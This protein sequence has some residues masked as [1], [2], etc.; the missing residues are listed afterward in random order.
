MLHPCEGST[1]ASGSLSRIAAQTSGSEEAQHTCSCVESSMKGAVGSSVCEPACSTGFLG[2]HRERAKATGRSTLP[3]LLRAARTP[4]LQ[5]VQMISPE[6]SWTRSWSS[7]D[8][9]GRGYR[10]PCHLARVENTPMCWRSPPS[11]PGPPWPAWICA[12]SP[13]R[14]HRPPWPPGHPHMRRSGRGS[15]PYRQAACPPLR[16]GWVRGSD[17]RQSPRRL[18]AFG[19]LFTTPLHSHT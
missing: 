17:V 5:I 8:V 14:A 19:T 15:R 6:T 9:Q 11:A 13:P 3:L 1:R 4:V 16:R 7:V 2:S 10:R 12:G 18:Q